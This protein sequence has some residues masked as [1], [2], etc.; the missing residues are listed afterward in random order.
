M[1]PVIVDMEKMTDSTIMYESRPNKGLSLFIYIILGSLSALLIWMFLFKIDIT[2]KSNGMFKQN[3]HFQTVSAEIAGVLD[4]LFFSNGDYVYS[5]DTIAVLKNDEI[6]DTVESINEKISDLEEHKIALEAYK[7]YLAGDE[8]ELTHLTDNRYYSDIKVRAELL[9]A[10]FNNN[11]EISENKNLFYETNIGNVNKNIKDYES[12]I[13]KLEYTKKCIYER[14]NGFSPADDPYYN[15]IVNSYVDN[16]SAT[17]LS[18]N[19][20][21]SELDITISQ[22]EDKLYSLEP[23]MHSEINDQIK[24][25]NNNRN[26]L[27]AERNSALISLESQQI[28]SIEQQIEAAVEGKKTAAGTLES[29]K[30]EQLSA[31]D[32]DSPASKELTLTNEKNNVNN[33]INTLNEQLQEYRTELSTY[34]LRNGKREI[35]ANKTG[36]LNIQQAFQ[37]GEIIEAGTVLANIYPEKTDTYY[38]EVYVE[39][40]D[41]GKISKGQEVIFEITAYPSDEY[42]YFTG[43]VEIIPNNI[44][45]NS[46]TG[47]AYYVVEVSCDSDSLIDKNENKINIMNGM[48]CQAKMVIKNQSVIKYLLKKID[49]FD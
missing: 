16:Y 38:A 15:S 46:D 29:I 8:D 5:G 22:L 2:V 39:N 33:E 12:Q 21:I 27:I 35:K 1:K 19:N 30:A 49:L 13:Q 40:S 11:K 20:K 4:D 41:I 10:T 23:E 37:P 31:N 7:S 18:Y 43:K 42:G 34:D 26:N 24:E 6:T 45:I 44:Q 47:E 14:I 48:A 17:E 3:N 25:T 9:K 32:S 28:S 36:I